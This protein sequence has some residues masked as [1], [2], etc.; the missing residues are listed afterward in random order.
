MAAWITDCSVS[1]SGS[2]VKGAPVDTR[3]GALTADRLRIETPDPSTP[4]AVAKV[5]RQ[6]T[7]HFGGDGAIGITVPGVV[8][9]GTVLTAANIDKSWIGTDAKALFSGATGRPATVLNDADAAGVAE[10][11][12]GAG[13]GRDGV[14]VMITLGTGIGFAVFNDGILLPN[15]EMGHIEMHGQDAESQASA[16]VREENDESWKHWAKK[17]D[18]YLD[19]VDALLWPDLIIIGGG[20]S[21]KAEKFFPY[22]NTRAELVPAAL[23]N[24]AGIVGA[25]LAAAAA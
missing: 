12:F 10:M 6:I 14:V 20:V 24:D 22:L 15:V 8:K 11:R 18:E 7:E 1:T 17:V 19:R 3:T 9:H 25:A 21:K 13:K 4:E 16:R 5:V 23:Q 2:G